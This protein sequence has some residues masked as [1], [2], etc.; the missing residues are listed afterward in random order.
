MDVIRAKDAKAAGLTRYFT[1]KPCAKGHVAERMISNRR[2]IV[3]LKE[4]SATYVEYRREQVRKWAKRHPERKKASDARYQ[5]MNFERLSKYWREYTKANA[6]RVRER[7]R[8]YRAENPEKMAERHMKRSASMRSAVVA[9]TQ[10]ERDRVAEMYRLRNRLTGTTGVPHH[11]DHIV[12]ISKGGKHHPD[13]LRV[14]PAAANC[15]K[16][17]RM[18]SEDEF[19]RILQEVRREYPAL[20]SASVQT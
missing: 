14:V 11:V 18:L 9:L 16:Q 10:A 5:Q 3:C 15:R 12:P 17:A 2:C 13:N 6:E 1:G 4:L 8:R 7:M 19:D 20:Q